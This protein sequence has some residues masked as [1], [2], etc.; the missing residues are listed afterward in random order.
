M[1]IQSL[2]DLFPTK[3]E[4]GSSI[5]SLDDLSNAITSSLNNNLLKNLS[6]ILENYNGNDWKQYIKITNKYHPETVFIN[7]VIEIKIITWSS[8]CSSLIHDHP[9]NGCLL[10]VL[11]GYL[12]EQT[13]DNSDFHLIKETK[14]SI[15]NINYIEGN[16]ILHRIINKNDSISVSI[17][18][19]SPPKHSITYYK[20]KMTYNKT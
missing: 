1:N 14:L 18:I 6:N 13:F 8:N 5:Q 15:N 10:K 17:H 9:K 4:N 3:V 16:E 2:D 20:T 11:D 12:V 7:D 19:Y